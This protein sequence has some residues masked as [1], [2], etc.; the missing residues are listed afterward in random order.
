MEKLCK[1]EW[2]WSRKDNSRQIRNQNF[3]I[4]KIVQFYYCKIKYLIVLKPIT[5]REFDI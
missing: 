1:R 2:K 5:K 3:K 4:Q